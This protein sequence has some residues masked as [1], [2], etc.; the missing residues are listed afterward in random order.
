GR[1]RGRMTLEA[2]RSLPAAPPTPAG[3]T[4]GAGPPTGTGR[5]EVASLGPFRLTDGA[6]LADL[7]VAYR[8]DGPGPRDGPQVVVVHALTGSAD[9]AGDWWEPL[10]GPGRAL[11]TERVGVLC[12]NLLGGRYGTTGPT[13]IDPGTGRPY[14]AAFPSVSTR[15]QAAAHWRLLDAIGIES[16]ALIVGGSLGGMV[17]LETAVLRPTAVRH[18]M[19]IAAPAATGPM[20]IAWNHLQVELVDRL[21]LAGLS[22]ARQLAMTTYRSELDFE[23][24][25]GRR[26]EPDGRASIVS[27]LDHQGEK[28][29]E[30]FDPLT[31]RV[32]A[33]A[34]DRHD[35][36]A[37]RGGLEAALRS[38]AGADVAITGVGIQDDV[39]YGP[40]QVRGLVDAAARVGVTAQYREIRSTK[41][42]D[43]FLVEWDQLTR[44]LRE[45]LSP[46]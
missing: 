5:L 2:T 21:G 30:R 1:R 19:P 25:F 11:D 7:T 35:I 33:R 10:I 12:A 31:Y 20:A 41:G 4:T 29:V 26:V 46:A 23:E 27:Y 3:P 14:G 42:H 44:I 37:G 43:G 13:S 34:M 38:L 28:L 18:V 16:L 24:R 6:V 8:H 45:A 17:A 9:A 40:R 22:L 36:G 15:D 32:L 39:L